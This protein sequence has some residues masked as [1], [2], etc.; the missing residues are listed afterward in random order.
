MKGLVLICRW[1]RWATSRTNENMHRQLLEPS[2]NF[3]AGMPPKLNSSQLCTRIPVVKT[4]M[5]HVGGHFCSHIRT[6]SQAVYQWPCRRMCI[7]SVREPGFS[8]T[9][10]FR[11]FF[12]TTIW[13]LDPLILDIFS[14]NH[15][16]NNHGYPWNNYA[17]RNNEIF[18]MQA[19][20]KFKV[21][22]F[23]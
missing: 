19:A 1:Y 15:P 23:I 6:V 13:C 21:D 9:E 8:V 2:Q 22:A 11:W 20:N 7:G 3:T 12:F 16:S 14:N 4:G 18:T 10:C 17:Q 5:T